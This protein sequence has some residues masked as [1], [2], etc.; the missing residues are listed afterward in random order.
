MTGSL[1]IGR[2]AISGR[3][4]VPGSKSLTNRALVAAGLADGV[5]TVSGCLAGDDADAMVGGL[6]ALGAGIELER[7]EEDRGGARWR[8]EGTN[9]RLSPGPADIDAGLAGTVLRILTAVAA[10]G[11]GG[12]TVS[13]APGLL[14]RP[15]GP[16]LDA[17]RACGAD[18]SGSGQGGG[19]PPVRAGRRLRR[20][21]GSVSV[22]ASQSSQFV[23][24]LLMAAPCFD[25]PFEVAAAGLAAAGYVELTCELMEHFG[26]DVERPVRTTPGTQG[27]SHREIGPVSYRVRPGNGRSAYHSADYAVP[28]DASAASHLFTLAL[29]TVGE[30]TVESLAAAASQPDAGVLATLEAF[31]ATLSPGRDG[32]VSLRSTGRLQPVDVDLSAM[33]DQLPNVAILAALAPGSSRLTG[34]GVTRHHES[35]RMAAIAHELGKVGVATE[36]EQDAVVVHGGTARGGAMLSAHGDHRMAMALAALAAALGECRLEDPDVVSKTYRHFWRDAEGL[37]LTVSSR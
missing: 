26:V 22:D 17:L 2:S 12:I 7:D 10:I 19:F 35:D 31:G 24:A 27:A 16:L 3:A 33:P 25:D 28:P 37:G 1:R 15:V 21:G 18:V 4:R 29:A 20:L 11:E 34:V 36:L 30:V 8:V 14:R 9:G 23:T 6:R 32:E 5:S 13:G